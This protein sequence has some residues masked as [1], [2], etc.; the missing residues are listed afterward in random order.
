MEVPIIPKEV[1]FAVARVLE[2]H[3]YFVIKKDEFI[4]KFEELFGEGG[5]NYSKLFQ[6][7][8][9]SRS[10]YVNLD[11]LHSFLLKPPGVFS[12]IDAENIVNRI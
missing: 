4:S 6:D 8:D 7:I 12:S 5:I 11:K 2:K 9:V 1:K 3:L 10:G